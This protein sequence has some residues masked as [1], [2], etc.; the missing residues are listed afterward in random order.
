[1]SDTSTTGTTV[2]GYGT[3]VRS[4]HRAE[5]WLTG[6]TMTFRVTSAESAGE[7]IELELELRP[8]GAPGGAPHRHLPAERFHFTRGAVVAWI[9]GRRPRLAR[10]GD[11]VEVPPQRWHFLLAL[12]RSHAHV[13]I[14]PGMRFDEL[15]VTWAAVGRGDVRPATLLRL[16]PLLREHGC[17]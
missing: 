5:N 8:G 11:V 16:V 2:A 15:L 17:I 4:G 10:A 9:A 6:E 14:R 7:R 13:L 1:M 3:S 12:R